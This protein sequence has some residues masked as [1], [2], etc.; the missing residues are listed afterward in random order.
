MKKCPFCAE[1]IQDEAIKCRH[2]GEFLDFNFRPLEPRAEK[3]DV[4]WYFGYYFI[5]TVT[6]IAGPA[7]LPLIWLRPG[8]SRTTKAIL[9]AIILFVSWLMI[10]FTV[11]SLNNIKA[12]YELLN[13]M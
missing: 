6:F 3:K 5:L 9:T 10:K 13:T 1:E 2:C 7:S 12:Y 8:T 4:P 11:T